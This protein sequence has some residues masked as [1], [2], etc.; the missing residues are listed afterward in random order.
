M[1]RIRQDSRVHPPI[2]P[3]YLSQLLS[4]QGNEKTKRKTA[5]EERKQDSYYEKGF[6]ESW[7]N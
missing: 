7:R 3:G 6:I 1:S 5:E 2:Q 4:F